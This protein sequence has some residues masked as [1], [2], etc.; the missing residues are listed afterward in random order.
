MGASDSLVKTAHALL[1]EAGRPLN[2]RRLLAMGAAQKMW[3]VG[4]DA[5]G[6][7]DA[8]ADA[9]G[10]QILRRGVFAAAAAP[11]AEAPPASV[12][13]GV[14]PRR[15]RPSKAS[16]LDEDEFDGPEATPSDRDFDDRDKRR[17]KRTRSID[18]VGATPAAPLTVEDATEAA[19]RGADDRDGLRRRMWARIQR[20]AA[21]AAGMDPGPAPP[22]HRPVKPAARP[23]E[24]PVQQSPAPAFQVDAEPPPPAA[25]PSKVEQTGRVAPPAPA[26]PDAEDPSD[27]LKAALRRRRRTRVDSTPP[28]PPEALVAPPSPSEAPRAEPRPVATPVPAPPP[29]AYVEHRQGAARGHSPD[30]RRP[31][32]PELTASDALADAAEQVLLGQG[33]PVSLSGLVQAI[34]SRGL[35]PAGLAGVL[36]ADGARRAALGLRPRF[37]HMPDGAVALWAWGLS[38]HY[39]AL[40]AEL[41]ATVAALREAARRD[42][43]ARVGAASPTGFARIVRLLLERQG[44]VALEVVHRA[45][46]SLALTGA[47]GAEGGRVV[48]VAHQ[49]WSD[50][51]AQTVAAVGAN[52]EAFEVDEGL[53]ITLGRVGDKARAAAEGARVTLWDG[54]ALAHALE[55]HGVGLAEQR[56]VV[57]YPDHAFFAGLG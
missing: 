31:V 40:E 39:R 24:A 28:A 55:A 3:P 52:L 2:A 15:T 32:L 53:V 10:I 35:E 46:R 38:E 6:L 41:H 49:S 22:L 19:R 29:D 50:L 11:P 8:L 51:G 45:E 16:A 25:A 54:P 43:L 21:I 14:P 26:A 20:E 33:E 4:L 47:R 30:R 36:R 5:N 57:R 48:V 12:A 17:R 13:E 42:L 7:S 34:A 37:A 18:L 23:I 44:L 9:P 1:V 27:R 56:P